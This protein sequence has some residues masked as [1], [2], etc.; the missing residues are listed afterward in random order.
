[1][2]FRDNEVYVLGLVDDRFFNCGGF[3]LVLSFPLVPIPVVVGVVVR[4]DLCDKRGQISLVMDNLLFLV[5]VKGVQTIWLCIKQRMQL[6][7]I[8]SSGNTDHPSFRCPEHVFVVFGIGKRHRTFF[9]PNDTKLFGLFVPPRKSQGS[10][11]FF[12]NFINTF[13]VREVREDNLRVHIKI[14]VTYKGTKRRHIHSAVVSAHKVIKLE[15]VGVV[16]RDFSLGSKTIV[17][18]VTGH[19]QMSEGLTT[20]Q[21]VMFVEEF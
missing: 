5:V 13:L 20:G 15:G 16:C 12:P 6:H 18:N 14:S 7:T 10:V 3:F 9:V 17:S 21:L 2:E 11:S 4:Y 1:M 19:G 8:T